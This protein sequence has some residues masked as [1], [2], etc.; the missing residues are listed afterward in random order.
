MS[1]STIN[2]NINSNPSSSVNM[3]AMNV[4]DSSMKHFYGHR[5]NGHDEIIAFIKNIQPRAYGSKQKQHITSFA[6][7]YMQKLPPLSDDDIDILL[8]G[9]SISSNKQENNRNKHVSSSSKL[10]LLDICGSSNIKSV[11]GVKRSAV[12]GIQLLY[13]IC[14][15][16]NNPTHCEE[17]CKRLSYAPLYKLKAMKLDR[18]IIS[19]ESK[20]EIAYKLID[21]I[22]KYCTSYNIQQYVINND[23]VYK[24]QQWKSENTVNDNIGDDDITERLPRTWADI[25][26]EIAEE[27]ST[28]TP[29]NALNL[30]SNND[31][32]L[33]NTLDNTVLHDP[34]GIVKQIRNNDIKSSNKNKL[35]RNMTIQQRVKRL[36]T[37]M[38]QFTEKDNKSSS[39]SNNDIKT[40]RTNDSSDL[41]NVI[42]DE[43]L[44]NEKNKEK[45]INVNDEN[46][47]AELFLSSVHKNTTLAELSQGMKNLESA[48]NTRTIQMKNLVSEN[49]S[50]Y[51]Y[52]KQ[53]LSHLL[54]LLQHE[55]LEST[56]YSK[57][58]KS[59]QRIDS[60]LDKIAELYNPLLIR[61]TE[62]E[63]LKNSII[64][65]KRYKAFF[66][67]IGNIRRYTQNAQYTLLIKEYQLLKSIEIRNDTKNVLLS[68]LYNAS[69]KKKQSHNL[70]ID[71]Y[72]SA[73]NIISESREQLLMLYISPYSTVYQLEQ[74]VEWL[75]LLDSPTISNILIVDK[76]KNDSIQLF[77][78]Y[79]EERN[80]FES[81]PVTSKVEKLSHTMKHLIPLLQYTIKVIFNNNKDSISNNSKKLTENQEKKLYSSINEILNSYTSHIYTLF[82]S[83][84]ILP[85]VC[86][87]NMIYTL[88]LLIDSNIHPHKDE[89]YHVL[90]TCSTTYI[91]SIFKE[92][93]S[94]L[95]TITQNEDYTM[96]QS[97]TSD[98]EE[99]IQFT[100][101]VTKVKEQYMHTINHIIFIG[102][103]NE[104]SIIELCRSYGNCATEFF[105]SISKL[106]VKLTDNITENEDSISQRLLLIL[107]NVMYFNDT[108]YADLYNRITSGIDKKY[109]KQIDHVNESICQQLDKYEENIIHSYIS[110]KNAYIHTYITNQYKL[111]NTANNNSNNNNNINT[112]S[113]INEVTSVHSAIMHILL[114][115]IDIHSELYMYSKNELESTLHSI[116]DHLIQYLNTHISS[117]QLSS[118]QLF[119]DLT[120]IQNIL[121]YYLSNTSESLLKNMMNRYTQEIMSSAD[122]KSIRNIASKILSQA[123]K[124]TSTMFAPFIH[125]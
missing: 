26:L 28:S 54:E 9:S 65:T 76:L 43:S 115:L 35:E 80:G 120:F 29:M 73:M 84:S 27:E 45:S 69:S 2:N 10:G 99:N 3:T 42:N 20:P 86:I 59:K 107:N 95:V 56:S 23:A 70:L 77:N 118:L 47:D 11:F 64:L 24:Y 105:Q 44:L 8:Y 36:N 88:N 61:N 116:I 78:T 68:S 67:I 72:A 74:S 66:D 111:S 94:N 103:N 109:M 112:N 113:N 30:Q 31:T 18:H 92:C 123:E 117:I 38:K 46:F 124:N 96:K 98:S 41:S 4:L 49:Y 40:H 6:K 91:E 81:M 122:S 58:Y 25:T 52:S 50:S 13:M 16:D 1:S 100:T 34:L 17:I 71:I 19:D 79:I 97:F 75:D 93:S 89:L 106:V 82:A 32:L 60:I 55:T 14:T 53:T 83:Q 48:L 15:S 87:Q 51:V 21:I 101:M 119:I 90:R 121:H 85:T 57:T 12:L 22:C 37:V 63:R 5:S 104:W 39:S 33:D 114:Y 110:S 125:E 108:M 102:I 7:Y 62:V